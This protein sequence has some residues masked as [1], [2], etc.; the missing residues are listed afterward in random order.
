M[1]RATELRLTL[2]SGR[3]Q[4]A[5]SNARSGSKTHC[6]VHQLHPSPAVTRPFADPRL[7][8][9]VTGDH[10]EKHE[11]RSRMQAS[12]GWWTRRAPDGTVSRHGCVSSIAFVQPDE[13]VELLVSYA[14]ARLKRHVCKSHASHGTRGSRSQA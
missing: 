6:L 12:D 2:P 8:N 11:A 3:G 5:A 13:L 14:S 10:G 7:Q 4:A 1:Q 9:D